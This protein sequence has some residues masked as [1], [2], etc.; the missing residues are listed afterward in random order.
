MNSMATLYLWRYRRR[1]TS[2]Y[3]HPIRKIVQT[4]SFFDANPY[5]DL[6]SG[7]T[8]THIFHLVYQTPIEWY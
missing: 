7:P 5:H 4:S 1:A 8:I 2:T 6:V 3:A